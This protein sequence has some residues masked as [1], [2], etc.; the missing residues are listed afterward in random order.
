MQEFVIRHLAAG[1]DGE[2]ALGTLDVDVVGTGARHGGF[3]H[4]VAVALVDIDGHRLTTVAA[5]A[6]LPL[7][8][9]ELVEQRPQG[10]G[11]VVRPA[12]HSAD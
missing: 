10:V 1:A 3:D 11:L 4:Q 5:G 2:H 6:A 12:N 9:E 8:V 7:V